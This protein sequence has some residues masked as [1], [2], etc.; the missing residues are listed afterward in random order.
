MLYLNNNYVREKV[1]HNMYTSISRAQLSL[2][3]CKYVVY[4]LTGFTKLRLLR[5]NKENLFYV[6]QI[7]KVYFISIATEFRI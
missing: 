3:S 4:S 6:Q 1:S 5:R 2:N 7:R